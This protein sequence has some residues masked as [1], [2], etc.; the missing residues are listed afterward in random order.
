MWNLNLESAVNKTTKKLDEFISDFFEWVIINKLT[1]SPYELEKEIKN[2]SS[3][4][5]KVAQQNPT[6]R[7]FMIEFTKSKYKFEIL[8]DYFYQVDKYDEILE[9]GTKSYSENLQFVKDC[10]DYFYSNLIENET[11]LIQY[12]PNSEMSIKNN[13][14][15]AV[16]SVYRVCP[17]CDLKEVV[18]SSDISIDHFLPKSKYPLLS[19][20]STNLIVSCSGCNDRIKRASIYFPIFHPFKHRINEN[21]DLKFNIY[22]PPYSIKLLPKTMG[23]V[24][25]QVENYELLFNLNETYSERINILFYELQK[26]RGKVKKSYIKQ[27]AGRNNKSLIK[28]LLTME[29]EQAI[30]DKRLLKGKMQFSKLYLDFYNY[31]LE[32]NILKKQVNYIYFNNR[33]Q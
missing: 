27:R 31:L 32:E 5:C 2:C 29:I 11:F 28:T 12:Q 16:K 9:Q 10:F 33:I 13:F 4:L 23:I 14:R 30:E 3:K 24:K 17:Y 8:Y 7:K 6:L 19:I 20:N 1:K 22:L 18:H 15:N 25:E 21:I 26:L